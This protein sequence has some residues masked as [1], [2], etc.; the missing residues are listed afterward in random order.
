[1]SFG[2]QARQVVVDNLRYATE[3]AAM[4][5]ITILIEPLNHRDA[6][7]YFLATSAQAAEIIA[8]VD[9]PNLKLMF[10]CY[11]LQIMEGDLATSLGELLPIIGHVQIASVPSR[12]EPDTGELYYP[13]I[14]SVLSDLG[15]QGYVGAEYKP[16]STTEKGLAWMPSN[17]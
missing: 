9:A 5:D 11:H 2:A 15:Y 3:Q 1:V 4:Y 16:K 13:F 7:G 6:P 8:T 10:D 12:Q 17:T 14:F